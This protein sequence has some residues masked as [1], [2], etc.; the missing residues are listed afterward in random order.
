M[1]KVEMLG[2]MKD[3]KM[4]LCIVEIVKGLWMVYVG[5]MVVCI[6]GF[7]WVGMSGFDVICYGFLIM[8]LGG[9]L[10]YDVSF[11]YFDLLVI[12]VVVI[13]FMLIVGMNFGMFF[14]VV[15]GCL[16]WF[17]LYDLEVGWFFGVMLISILI[18]VIYIWKD[19]MYVEFDMVVCYVVFNFVLIV[20]IIGY[21]SVDFV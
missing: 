7:Y 20:I 8:G 12:E 16:L 19:G 9:F 10:I 21:V 2:L 4:M 11:G 3:M 14:F 18:V 17:Y 6:L 15:I 5:V 1:F 13:G